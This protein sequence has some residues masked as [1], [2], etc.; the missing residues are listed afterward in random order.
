MPLRSSWRAWAPALTALA[1]AAVAAVHARAQAPAFPGVLDEHPAIKYAETPTTDVVAMLNQ[2]LAE[3]TRT[4]RRDDRTGFLRDVL[5]ALDV[6]PESQLLVFS[7]TGVQRAT[8]G[9][10]HPRALYYNDAVAVGYIPGASALELAA[11][12]RTQG[13]VFYTLDQQPGATPRFTRQTTCLT[14]HVAAGTLEVPGFI[15][16][17]HV[18]DASGTP[19]P[20]EPVVAVNHATPHTQRWGGWFVTSVGAPPP[21][22]PMGHLGNLTASPHPTS[23]PPIL[24]NHALIEWLDTDVGTAGYLSTSSDLAALLVFDHQTY[25]ANLLTRLGWE[26]RV[27]AS[28]GGRLVTADVRARVDELV[29][30][31]LFVNEAAPA[32][33]V[34]PRPG[35]QEH[36]RARVPADAR[37]RSLADLEIVPRSNLATDL[38][39]PTRLFRYSCSFM[40]YSAAFDG[41]PAEVKDAVYRRLFAVL[42]GHITGARYAQLTPPLRRAAR[43]IL[44]ET[45]ADLPGAVRTAARAQ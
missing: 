44:L 3:G 23:G 19:L 35:F 6:A 37:G 33:E 13:V 20:K 27:A 1:T 10:H 14:C 38:V 43:E 4:L 16:R 24:S 28:G 5:D 17:S 31:L 40:I 41:L 9:P 42:D 22:Q 12:D 7:K 11:L 2:A 26:A 36:L 29:D 30:Y 15:V 25:A 39:P 32:V 8:T 21:Y 45:K 34:S 18:V